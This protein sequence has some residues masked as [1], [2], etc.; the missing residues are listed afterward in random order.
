MDP[1]ETPIQIIQPLDDSSES[2]FRRRGCFSF[3]CFD[4]NPAGPT[5]WQRIRA[6]EISS[7]DNSLWLRGVGAVMKIRE[8]SELVTG[9]RW[10][11]FIRRKST[12]VNKNCIGIFDLLAFAF[13]FMAMATVG[14]APERI[15][16]AVG[17]LAKAIG[18]EELSNAG[19]SPLS[20][21]GFALQTGESRIVKASS[22]WG[23]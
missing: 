1:R 4:R 6:A 11:T 16:A 12:L 23:G 2:L 10:K 13:E 3:P 21:T 7:S 15:L 9:P 18:T 8:W 14:V 20:T 5:W 19:I 17:E 22:S